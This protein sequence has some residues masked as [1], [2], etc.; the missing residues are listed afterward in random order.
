M[1]LP[2]D[3]E[4]DLP[5]L[6]EIAAEAILG[7]AFVE[8]H[9][10]RIPLLPKF[11]DVHELLSVQA[12][13]QGN[14]EAYVVVAAD[15]GATLGLGFRRDV[16]ATVLGARLA[17]ARRAQERLLQLVPATAVPTGLVRDLG[18][19]VLPHVG[20]DPELRAEVTEI[21]AQLEE[22]SAE[23]LGAM[24]A[25]PVRPGDVID[26]SIPATRRDAPT[27]EIHAL[28]NPDRREILLLEVRKPGP[29]LRAWDH[30]RFPPRPLDIDAALASASTRATRVEDF[31]AARRPVP[32]RP[33]VEV[34]VTCP[35]FVLEHLS[36][37]VA[38]EASLTIPRDAR[39]RTLHVM[40]G[41]VDVAGENGA[42]T[43]RLHR[44][45]SALLPVGLSAL[46][47][48]SVPEA[49][50]DESAQLLLVTIP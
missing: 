43:R 48:T 49:G 13:P 7:R 21:V 30:A 2:D 22:T 39:V 42:R 6:L 23:V 25:V 1:T 36:P 34:S 50:G 40:R 24:N 45:S 38:S 27:A 29:S 3:S 31:R 18:A 8:R 12:H 33:G 15:E 44:G 28:G 11:L 20:A 46:R 5:T 14:P 9:G 16:D 10:R 47:V 19:S 17:A 4:I 37:S 26:N 35:Y 32:G 41:A